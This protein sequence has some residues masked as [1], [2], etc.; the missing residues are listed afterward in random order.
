MVSL[1]EVHNA[2]LKRVPPSQFT[3]IRDLHT[4]AH[5][6]AVATVP[7]NNTASLKR[8]LKSLQ[9]TRLRLEAER[10]ELAT[11][12]Y[13]MDKFCCGLDFNQFRPH[14]ALGYRPPAPAAILPLRPS[15]YL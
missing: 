7:S 14:S 13:E 6:T 11:G 3:A 10:S 12:I 1:L 2:A 4:L 15:N 8:L 9:L 5:K